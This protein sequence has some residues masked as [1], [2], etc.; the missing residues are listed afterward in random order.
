VVLRDLAFE[1][2][3]ERLIVFRLTC[4]AEEAVPVKTR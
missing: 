4:R 1:D 3:G 2:W